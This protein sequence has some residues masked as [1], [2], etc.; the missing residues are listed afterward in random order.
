MLCH[1]GLPA[2]SAVRAVLPAIQTLAQQQSRPGLGW[3]AFREASAFSRTLYQLLGRGW[4]AA[5]AAETAWRR[6]YTSHDEAASASARSFPKVADGAGSLFHP[7]LWPQQLSVQELVDSTQLTVLRREAAVLEAAFAASISAAA[8]STFSVQPEQ[9]LSDLS[10]WVC[11]FPA[12]AMLLPETLLLAC[13]GTGSE[14]SGDYTPHGACPAYGNAPAVLRSAAVQFLES[15]SPLDAEKRALL[16]HS[17]SERLAP[18]NASWADPFCALRT[19]AVAA[20]EIVTHPA[21]ALVHSARMRAASARGRRLVQSLPFDMDAGVT[22]AEESAAQQRHDSL[23]Q[24]EQEASCTALTTSEAIMSATC[25]MLLSGAHI[26]AQQAEAARHV[27]TVLHLALVRAADPN[28][29]VR[30]AAAHASTDALPHVFAAVAVLEAAVIGICSSWMCDALS[31]DAP[32]KLGSTSLAAAR[33]LK[34]LDRLAEWRSRC[35]AIL[36]DTDCTA[37]PPVET[38]VL[39]WLRMRK[40]LFKVIELLESTHGGDEAASAASVAASAMDA[41]CG[42]SDL[43]APKPLLWRF[44][45]HPSFPSDRTMHELEGELRMLA[46]S[47]TLAHDPGLRAALAQAVCFFSWSH[48]GAEHDVPKLSLSEASAMHALALTKIRSAELTH[49]LGVD[50]VDCAP[51]PAE[52]EAAAAASCDASDATSVAAAATVPWSLTRWRAAAAA[53]SDLRALA[54]IASFTASLPVLASLTAAACGDSSA[55]DVTTAVPA[56]TMTTLLRYGVSA[57]G[58][59]PLDFAPLQQIVWLSERVQ[60]DAAAAA[61]LKRALPV[62]SHELW[63]R[64]HAAAWTVPPPCRDGPLWATSAGIAPLFRPAAI[65]KLFSMAFAAKSVTVVERPVT[66]L[67][68]RLAARCLRQGLQLGAVSD[69]GSEQLSASADRRAVNMLTLQLMHAYADAY[70]PLGKVMALLSVCNATAGASALES[71]AA[72]LPPLFSS[73]F[74]PLVTSLAS[75]D[76][77]GSPEDEASRGAAWSMLGCARLAL[78]AAELVAD[79]AAR[80]AFKL[81]HVRT[82][83]SQEL[84]PEV[85]LRAAAAALPGART[86]ERSS[87]KCQM[88]LA[89][90]D[91]VVEKLVV[92]AVPRPADSTWLPARAEIER[93]VN[94]LGCV[95][96]SASRHSIRRQYA[97]IYATQGRYFGREF[98]RDTYQT[99]YSFGA[100][101]CGTRLPLSSGD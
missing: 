73:L 66:L 56:A 1:G 100:L 61:Q 59:S 64:F 24:T 9:T 71:A 15:C 19:Y 95:A 50:A 35:V 10:A 91:A 38:I 52:I 53:A 14:S 16:L 18:P 101:H 34:P 65:M 58:R 74:L 90:A 55:L 80:D 40:S 31:V 67:K 43:G 13:I 88:A 48:V 81:G 32:D 75:R 25:R 27:N 99:S 72:T 4:S 54:A 87:Y 7:L 22:V 36:G 96:P 30:R 77:P 33:L 83:R 46:E 70:P 86:F 49:E 8:S 62:A 57:T 97:L 47:P 20:S 5:D 6:A 44:A 85:Q 60:D 28:E 51:Q 69:A 3:P 23:P 37:P 21:V 78:L 98:V 45:G 29:R 41:C 84:E 76:Q 89:R 17:L 2:G 39:A 93:F 12:A 92:R 26:A 11:A 94:G 79:P 68:L 63:F 82:R 42:I